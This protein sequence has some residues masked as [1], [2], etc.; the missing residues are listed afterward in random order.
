MHIW[1]Y[2][3]SLNIT[4][5]VCITLPVCIFSALT[6]CHCGWSALPLR[7]PPLPRPASL[8][9]LC[10]SVGRS[11]ASWAFLHPVWACPSVSCLFSRCFWHHWETNL[12]ASS[13]ILW[14][15]PSFCLIFRTVPWALGPPQLLSETTV[16]D[17]M[18]TAKVDRPT[19]VSQEWSSKNQKFHVDILSQDPYQSACRLYSPAIP[20]SSI[21]LTEGS[22]CC[23]C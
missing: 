23:S 18:L 20:E 17:K 6:I 4:R 14:L 2:I 1:I 13:L 3:Y 7:R 5:L 10:S 8:V 21:H 9:C 15:W 11:E 22:H 12:T 19:V 16:E